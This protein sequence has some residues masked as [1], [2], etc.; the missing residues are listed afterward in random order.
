MSLSIFDNNTS[1][2]FWS[3]QSI[4]PNIQ[5]MGL[6]LSIHVYDRITGL[7]I[8]IVFQLFVMNTHE[9]L[10]YLPDTTSTTWNTSEVEVLPLVRVR[11]VFEA[12]IH[13][14]V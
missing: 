10:R 13:D 6:H 12:F 7:N 3:K 2:L 8:Y 4:D 14:G 9:N 1:V 11:V 5:L